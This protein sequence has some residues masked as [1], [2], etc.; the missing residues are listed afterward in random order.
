MLLIIIIIKG[1]F[2]DG[3]ITVSMQF[4]LH[5]YT[6]MQNYLFIYYASKVLKRMWD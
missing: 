2:S 1:I 3:F 6:H 5:T 4:T